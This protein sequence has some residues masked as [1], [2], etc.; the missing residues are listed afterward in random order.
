MKGEGSRGFM[1]FHGNRRSGAC[2]G[3]RRLE[4]RHSNRR[5][6]AHPIHRRLDAR[7]VPIRA[8]SPRDPRQLFDLFARY[9]ESVSYARFLADL[10]RK[11]AIILLR[12][13]GTGLIR[14]FSTIKDL[15]L[16]VDGRTMYGLFSGDTVVERSYWGQRVLGRAFLR[17][18]WWRKLS[19]PLSPFYWFLISKGY[20][21][22]LLMANNFPEH[23]PRYETAT[24]PD[25]QRIL[26]A[27]ARSLFPDE[28]DP[29][30]GLITFSGD[31]GHLR[32]D[33]APIDPAL[34]EANPRVAFFAARNP[35]WQQGTELGCIARM[36][37]TLPLR[38]GLR[39]ARRRL[40]G[41]TQPLS[42]PGPRSW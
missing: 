39:S 36:T 29:A 15:E 3:N 40:H 18:V 28:Y 31:A 17:Y 32:P 7:V 42:A 22:Y 41:G 26:E 16:E 21:T 8:L 38:Y 24:P 12:E 33:T 37:W 20:K 34:V 10:E 5:L 1:A 6:E 11:D 4:V 13:R 25:R 27:F 23:Y 19:H 9:Y 35:T 14:G 30:T 2:S